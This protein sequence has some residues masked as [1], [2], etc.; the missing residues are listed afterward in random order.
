MSKT[1]SVSEHRTSQ[2]NLS[3][4]EVDKSS[5][6]ARYCQIIAWSVSLLVSA[7]A[8]YA[9]GKT[10]GWHLSLSPY[11]LF[12]LLGLLAFSL[13]WAH[14]V[15]GFVRQRLQV[16]KAVLSGYFEKTSLAVLILLFLHPGLL[17][18]QRF[19]DGYGLPPHSY[20]TYVAPGL[21]WVTLIGTVS[22]C[23]FIAYEFRR[24]FENRKWWQYVAMAG[25]FAMLG[26]VYHSLRLGDQLQ[27]GWYRGV[28]FGYAIILVLILIN[29]YYL[30]YLAARTALAK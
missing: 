14:Y 8:I 13:M 6:R 4:Q 11:Q 16:E 20:E 3:T 10:S 1:V 21:G 19:R 22:W 30:K 9:W 25:D 23:I 27:T 5:R 12:P 28:W 2:V 24:K 18:Y 7:L 17:I 15:A 29:N 26:I